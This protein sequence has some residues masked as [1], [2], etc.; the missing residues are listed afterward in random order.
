MKKCK[1]CGIEKPLDQYYKMKGMK[2]GLFSSCK[3]CKREVDLEYYRKK[4][5][6][7]LWVEKQ[8]ARHREK[9]HRL[10]Y[11]DTYTR[12]HNASKKERWERFKV[13]FPEMVKA[14]NLA[15]R[16][17]KEKGFNLHHWSYDEKY[18]KDVIRLTTREHGK[19]HRFLRYDQSVYMYKDLEGNLLD[20]REKHEAYIRK[21]ITEKED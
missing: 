11:K 8:K 4:M 20:T 10:N 17:P 9:N 6:D 18:A 19:A 14:T 7:P 3:S 2:D 5:Q 15:R 12:K 16:L 13:E 21:M 1:T